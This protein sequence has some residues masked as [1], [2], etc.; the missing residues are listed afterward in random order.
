MRN[1]G[2][3]SFK[4][5]KKDN[6]SFLSGI[7]WYSIDQGVIL[8]NLY[9]I[10][11]QYICNLGSPSNPRYYAGSTFNLKKRTSSHRYYTLNWNKYKDNSRICP[12]FYRSVSKYDWSVFKFGILE[13][14]DL[15]DEIGIEQRKKIILDIEQYYLDNINPS[16]NVSKIANS[17]LG[18]KTNEMRS[19]NLSK[20][21]RGKKF[22]K[23]E[24][25]PKDRN[26]VKLTTHETK[27]K[28]SLRSHGVSVKILDKSGNLIQE[29]ATISETAK[30]LGVSRKT[31]SNIYQR[32]ESFDDF[33]YEFN[34]TGNR[35]KVYDA[36][37]QLLDILDNLTKTSKAYDIPRTTLSKD[38]KTRKLYKNQYYFFTFRSRTIF[39]GLIC[40]AKLIIII[41]T[42]Q[43]WIG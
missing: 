7:E 30:Y 34:V 42:R 43:G 15:P 12:I 9:I 29:F 19:V 24:T 23:Y 2:I 6:L 37:K 20:A 31:V 27:L 39:L 4:N 16:L 18:A 8:I 40:R 28:I 36:N 21:L 41:K 33:I 38:I 35:I 3:Q 25:G 13:Y 32:G 11:Q 14:V 26:T 1:L 10:K 5:Y 17:G 22:K